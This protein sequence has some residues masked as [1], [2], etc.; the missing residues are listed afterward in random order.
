MSEKT[1]PVLVCKDVEGQ[2]YHIR[3]DK[4]FERAISKLMVALADIENEE[5]PHSV[6]TMWLE[7]MTQEDYDRLDNILLKPSLPTYI[8]SEN[9]SLLQKG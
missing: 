3:M 4:P 6:C 1:I 8:N 7:H 5:S 2:L 9:N